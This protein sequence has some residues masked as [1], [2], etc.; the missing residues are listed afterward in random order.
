MDLDDLRCR[1]GLFLPGTSRNSSSGFRRS[2]AF[3]VER[4]KLL[5]QPNV[6]IVSKGRSERPTR[7]AVKVGEGGS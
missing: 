5:S 2:R 1:A 6:R 3:S 4:K 7:K